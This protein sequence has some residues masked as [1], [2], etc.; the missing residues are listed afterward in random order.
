MVGVSEEVVRLIYYLLPGFLAAW[1]FYGL[2]AHP[3]PPP[4][5]RVVQALI[6]TAIIQVP[7]LTLRELFLFFG[8]HVFA[9]TDW[10]DDVALPWS[11]LIAFALGHLL[12]WGTNTNWYHERLIKW[13]I[14]QKTS[15]P[16]EWFNTF[17][18][19]RRYITLH[20]KNG[21]R[22][23]GWPFEWP[24]DPGVGHFV[25]MQPEWVLDNNRRVP[26][27]LDDKILIPVSDVEMV[28]FAK[29]P[30]EAKD[31]EDEIKSS[32]ET[33]IALRKEDG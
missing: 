17:A 32:E 3:K 26:V 29:W 15:S 2:T 10:T 21:R 20:L 23:F 14:T 19:E 8:N 5:E 33:L 13:G 25:M 4:F 16:S 28:E 30:S 6:L 24:N 12:A 22:L 27:D 1:I 9:I 31:K 11:L 18:F 7:L